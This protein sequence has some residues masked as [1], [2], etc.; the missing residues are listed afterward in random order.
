MTTR[1]H[2]VRS[3]RLAALSFQP[4]EGGAPMFPTSPPLLGERLSG[5]SPRLP[6]RI[7]L[8]TPAIA[9]PSNAFR[10]RADDKRADRPAPLESGRGEP[11]GGPAVAAETDDERGQRRRL[12]DQ[13]LHRRIK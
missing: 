8:L 6:T 10:I 13:P 11:V 12:S 3:W 1:C 2:S 5:S 4:S 7:T 9:L